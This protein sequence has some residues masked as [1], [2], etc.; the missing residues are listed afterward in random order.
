MVNKYNILFISHTSNF[1]GAEK[2]L[3]LLLKYINKKQFNPVVCIPEAKGVLINFLKQLRIKYYVVPYKWW[4]T[5]RGVDKKE[6]FFYIWEKIIYRFNKLNQIIKKEKINLIYTNTAVILDGAIC[7]K[8]NNISHI[9]HL[10]EN[11]MERHNDLNFIYGIKNHLNLI[12]GFSDKVIVPSRELKLRIKKITK[13]N[14]KIKVVYNGLEVGSQDRIV[15]KKINLIKNL[16]EKGYFLVGNIGNISQTKNQLKLIEVLYTYIKNNP[17]T[18][19]VLCGDIGSQE[20]MNK[21]NHFI[22]K[23]NLE[24]RVYFMGFIKNINQFLYLFDTIIIFSLAEV[25]P[26]IMLEAL[27]NKVPIIAGKNIGGIKEIIED[28]K[29]GFLIST[30]SQ[31]ELSR[32]LDE[33]RNNSKLVDK[34][35]ENGYRLVVKNF[36]IQDKVKQI[37]KIMI[38]T[39]KE[40]EKKKQKKEINSLVNYLLFSLDGSS[41]VGKSLLEENLKLLT[42]NQLIKNSRWWKL[43]ERIK[44][45]YFPLL[46]MYDIFRLKKS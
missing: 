11:F 33:I 5:P 12:L 27:Y 41:F 8:L 6:E 22:K 9:W 21:I 18:I 46:K 34:I 40:Y 38:D 42:E 15:D 3:Y 31:E 7:A 44:K 20:Y 39:L 17:K 43:R 14:N 32:I 36:L 30:F 28:K 35:R 23:H 25:F 37:E 1:A 2:F 13:Q 19:I 24:K 10:H 26:Y 45:F 4:V 16:K 29:N